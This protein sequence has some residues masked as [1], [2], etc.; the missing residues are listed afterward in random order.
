MNS[1][2]LCVAA[3]FGAI[4]FHSLSSAWAATPSIPIQHFF[5][6]PE[7]SG[8]ILSPSGRFLATK[9]ASQG[10]RQG[11][12]VLN[13]ADGSAA[14]VAQFADADIGNI[15]WVNEERLLFNSTDKRIGQGDAR[16]APGLYAVDRDGKNYRQLADRDGAFYQERSIVRLLPWHTYMLYQ[17]GAQKSDYVYVRNLEINIP[18]DL[19]YEG[20]LR[21][22]TRTG[23]TS[24]V[25]RPTYTSGWLLDQNG[26]P[27]LTWGSE[28]GVS[29]IYLSE[30]ANGKAGWRK[31]AEFAT[32]THSTTSF[33]PLSFGPDGV[34]YVIS[35]G[36]K[37]KAAVHTFDIAKG[38][39]NDAPLIELEGFDF[40]GYLIFNKEKLLGFRYTGESRDTL[41]LDSDMKQM[42]ADVDA[43]LRT[44]VNL[45]TLPTQPE[46]PNVLVTAYSDRQPPVVFV[47]NQKTKALTKVGESYSK[48]K[49]SEMAQRKFI[50]YKAR[51]GLEIPAILTIPKEKLGG[52]LPLVVLVHGG[53]WVRG[54]SWGWDTDAQFLASRGYTVLE[55][56]FRGS[57][58]FGARHFIAGFKQWG[59]KM[60]DDLADGARWA[61]AEG[62]ADPQRICI[63]GASYGGYATLMGLARNPELFKCG[64]NWVGVTDI[65]LMYTG[66]WSAVSDLPE[67]WKEY[68]MPQLIGDPEKDAEQLNATSPL[69]LAARIRQPL[70]LAYGGADQR[71]PIYH[72]TK[73]RDA[74]KAHNKDVE[75]IEYAEEGHGWTLPKNRID[76]WGRVE[77]FLDRNIGAG[78]KTE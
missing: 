15:S 11:L 42:Q 63:A 12:A 41:W 70:L 31:L 50:R 19:R 1:R 53:P 54:S 29:S 57:D 8:A 16:Y 52:K 14:L 78:A 60:Q 28:K 43:K 46:T 72:G 75:W 7:F 10:R 3:L 76:F 51:D 18:G 34:L 13:L 40:T 61:I 47:Y 21:L 49:A 27:R 30:E 32:Y 71:V 24:P 6:N 45:L 65:Q 5:E 67:Q 56:E 64:I 20:L 35:H 25:S 23:Q 9:V 4:V 58:G 36:G 62:M 44:T 39:V 2:V 17:D 37:D 26:E 48:I 68:G 69:L 33:T 22:N 74:V 38:K 66:H 55:P 77:K 73:F 59:L